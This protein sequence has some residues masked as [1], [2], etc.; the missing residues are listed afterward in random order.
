MQGAP[1]QEAL[2][3]FKKAYPSAA[4]MGT[5][6][7][8]FGADALRFTL[9]TFPPSNKR[10]ALALKRLEGYKH[11]LNKIWNATRFSLEN[12]GPIANFPQIPVKLEPK[13]LFNRWILGRLDEAARIASKGIGSFRIDEAALELYRFFWNDLCDWYLEI[14]KSIL[15]P[16]TPEEARYQE[17]K[18]ETKLTL[19]V[20][21]EASLRLMHPLMPYITEELWQRV[22]KP[23][24]HAVSVAL[25]PYP[26]PNGYFSAEIDAQVELL[27]KVISAVRTVRSEHEIHPAALAPVTVL[28]QNE[29]GAALLR[30]YASVIQQLAKTNGPPTIAKEGAYGSGTVVTV[31][32]TDAGPMDLQI[33]LKGL[34]SAEK[35][36]TR[37]E[38]EGKRIDKD[39]A[40]IE[41]KLSSK[42]FAEKAPKEVVDEAHAQLAAMKEAKVRLEQARKLADELD[43]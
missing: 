5:G 19:A 8:A 4:Q 3:K 28:T 41:K 12:I 35:E 27:K 29:N 36:R 16:R 30:E 22:P 34:V 39:I 2:A 32:A 42:A 43:E 15:A 17:H 23:A 20:V 7:P 14:T 24:H 11:F 13:F 18:E 38:R 40:S 31:V 1:E 9:A 10:I 26:S 33:S 37:V 6:F 21:L 25:A